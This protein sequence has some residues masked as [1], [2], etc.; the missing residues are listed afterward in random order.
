[1]RKCLF[2]AVMKGHRGEQAV[3]RDEEILKPPTD[4]A[5]AAVQTG[6]GKVMTNEATDIRERHLSARK[7]SEGKSISRSRGHQKDRVLEENREKEGEKESA[8][9]YY[10]SK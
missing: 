9:R 4:G 1:M 8:P 3:R 10:C 6:R 5:R 2:V 7:T